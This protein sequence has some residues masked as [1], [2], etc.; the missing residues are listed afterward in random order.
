MLFRNLDFFL[1]FFKRFPMRALEFPCIATNFVN[2]SD[3]II[4]FKKKEP[5]V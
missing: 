5:E 3:S 4:V 1:E 2:R